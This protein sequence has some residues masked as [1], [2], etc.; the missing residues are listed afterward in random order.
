M[1]GLFILGLWSKPQI[2]ML[3]LVLCCGITGPSSG[4]LPAI[5]RR[6]AD[7]IPAKSFWW[8]VKEKFPL[9]F[10]CIVDAG[11]T[12]I[13][14][15]VAGEQQPYTLWIRIENALVSYTATYAKPSGP[16]NLALYYPHPGK[17]VHWWQVWASIVVSGS[18]HPA[19][20]A[21]PAAQVLHCGMAVVPHYAGP[22]IGLVQVDVQ[23]MADRYAYVSFIGLFL[24][25]CWGVSD[26]A[27]ERHLPKAVLPAAVS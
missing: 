11:V 18:H 14:Q 7:A 17:Y 6:T 12:M 22:C 15:H 26:W 9:F 8:L 3:P 16:R 5:V 2:I 10:I 1:T 25:T 21:G 27:A 24:M 19:G 23:G 4:C 13:A 20:G